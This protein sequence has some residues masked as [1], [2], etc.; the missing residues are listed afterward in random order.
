MSSHEQHHGAD[1]ATEP[2]PTPKTFTVEGIREGFVSAL[3]L[4]IAVA[5]FSLVFG[6]LASQTGLS[7]VESTLMSATVFAGA[8]QFVVIDL[9]TDPLP[10]LTLVGA[11][12]TVN[13]RYVLF[14]ATLHRW[15]TGLP[16]RV[17]Y[18]SLFVMADENWALSIT[19]YKRGSNNG[20]FLF[21]SG[22]A[23]W[24]PWVSFTALGTQV[25]AVISDPAAFGLDVVFTAV[26][27][28]L[29]VGV[30]DDR[31][32]VV[33]WA[34]AAIVA[35]VAE[36]LL[37]GSWFIVLGGLSGSAIGVVRYDADG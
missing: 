21:G 20:A 6:V 15:V 1:T 35:I 10:V 19:E 36:Q 4:S 14:G 3:P 27:L 32:E 11:A 17:V 5:P 16:A 2:T 18:P 24:I 28:T 37:S 13:L 8:A 34:G 7:V 23:L 30:W 33:P 25:G 12:F 26:F 9:W 29:L 31:S 22:I